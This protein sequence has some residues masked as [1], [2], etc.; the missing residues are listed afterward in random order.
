[1][2][3]FA[4]GSILL[5]LNSIVLEN[6]GRAD[7]PNGLDMETPSPM[8]PRASIVLRCVVVCDD[9]WVGNRPVD[10]N[11]EALVT[12]LVFV[13][14][15][16]STAPGRDGERMPTR[17]PAISGSR[18]RRFSI[19]QLG[20]RLG[21]L[22]S[23]RCTRHQRALAPFSWTGVNSSARHSENRRETEPDG[24]SDRHPL[25][26]GDQQENRLR[27][28]GNGEPS[29]SRVGSYDPNHCS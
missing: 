23:V 8:F 10:L 15:F 21:S 18:N 20:R 12:V 5:Q 27:S 2:C 16:G 11:A 22:R 9:S 1:M 3:T 4:G 25:D 24:P 26:S 17:Y 29:F 28:A 6:C 13:E 19:P 14:H 7:E